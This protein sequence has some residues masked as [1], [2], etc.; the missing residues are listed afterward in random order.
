[1]EVVLKKQHVIITVLS[2]AVIALS[3]LISRNLWFRL[4]LT[5]DQMYTISAVSRNLYTEIPDQVGITYYLSEK[6]S[7]IHPIPGEIEDL[8]REYAAYSHG[9]IRV[10]VRDPV[11]ANLSMEMEMLGIQPQQIQTEEQDQTSFAT[12]YSGIAIEYLDQVEVLP[13][14][15]SLDTLEYD[16][17]SRIRSL[18]QGDTR[19]IGVL[20]GD[21]TRSL[22]N[23]YE[24]IGQ[25][26]DMSGFRLR[27]FSVG[28]EIPASLPALFVLGGTEYLDD[29]SLY[30]IDHYIQNGG[31][32]LF[33]VEGVFIDTQSMPT[34][35]LMMDKG[36]LSMVSFYGATVKPELALD[37]SALFLAYTTQN[38]YGALQQR[39]VQ[40]PLWIGVLSQNGNPSHPLTA[41]FNG[42]DL[43]WPNHLELNPPEGIQAEVLFTSTEQAWLETTDFSVSPDA[44]AYLLEAE[45]AATTG[46]KTFGAALS[47]VF[48]SYFAGAAKPIREGSAEELPELP[49]TAKESRII[50]IA[51]SDVGSA[52]IQR[53][54]NLDFLV[55]AALWLCA[56]D[57]IISI[58]S[59]QS[60]GARL[61]KIAN[62]Q[63]EAAAMGWARTLNVILIPLAV[64]IMGVCLAWQRKR[65][66]KGGNE[67]V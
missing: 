37:R 48:P 8:L 17:T 18:V 14:V 60:T 40:Y 49:A 27:E 23:D 57:D 34:A 19:E 52:Y 46:K 30:R 35:R 4:D 24:Y 38:A 53:R 62:P 29:W 42:L 32:V 15:F 26:F 64:I 33:A 41:R 50:V 10:S 63:R 11:K 7:A 55:Q 3:L 61:D 39:Y 56:D 12:V 43:F 47:G 65:R 1:M 51:D 5:T 44:P 54:Q 13:M 31:K 16:L 9:K 21:S 67:H 28:E 2:I 6:L 58:R 45:V 22:T 20:V 66:A 25:I 36:L 59:R